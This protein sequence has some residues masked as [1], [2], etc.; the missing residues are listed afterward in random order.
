MLRSILRPLFLVASAVTF[1][2][3]C[4]EIGRTEDVAANC[5]DHPL[6]GVWSKTDTGFYYDIYDAV[7]LLAGGK[8]IRDSMWIYD[9]VPDDGKHELSAVRFVG[10]WKETEANVSVDWSR[11][12]STKDGISWTI[13]Q[14]LPRKVPFLLDDSTA[15]F[16]KPTIDGVTKRVY[17]RAVVCGRDTPPKDLRLVGSASIDSTSTLIIG[18][19]FDLDGKVYRNHS[20]IENLTVHEW[21]GEW[22]TQ[23][24]ILT[25]VWISARAIK[26]TKSEDLPV[27]APMVV[28]YSLDAMTSRIVIN[29]NSGTH[30]VTVG[31]IGRQSG[32]G[33]GDD[34]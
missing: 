28:A 16:L 12:S 31:T 2:S 33:G 27:P 11:F 30:D 24:G 14:P 21:V 5:S 20:T 13:D 29:G 19:K 34:D 23:E 9:Q 25:I 6:V 3:G 1:F 8:A 32:G 17:S 4:G 10:T 18:Y 7:T 26:P 15:H 22:S